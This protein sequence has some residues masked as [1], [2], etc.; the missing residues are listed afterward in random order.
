MHIIIITSFWQTT[1]NK[2]Q[3][4]RTDKKCQKNPIKAG[5]LWLSS[6]VSRCCIEH[7]SF[8]WVDKLSLQENHQEMRHP[9][10]IKVWDI[11]CD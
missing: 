11:A 9:N 7:L 4:T 8:S 5:R 3:A 2:R 1:M 10:V 6:Y